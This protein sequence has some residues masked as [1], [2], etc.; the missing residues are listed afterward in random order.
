MRK[1]AVRAPGADG[2]K[3]TVI[4]QV[5]ACGTSRWHGC[6]GAAGPMARPPWRAA[7]RR[8]GSRTEK[9]YRSGP[10]MLTWVIVAGELRL[11]VTVTGLVMLTWTGSAGKDRAD[12]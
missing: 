6:G 10:P 7:S 5:C 3:T 2:V 12:G 1:S 9:S 8:S 4:V 11:S